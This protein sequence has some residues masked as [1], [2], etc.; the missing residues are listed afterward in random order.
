MKKLIIFFAPLTMVL[1]V[2][3]NSSNNKKADIPIP[4]AVSQQE[5]AQAQKPTYEPFP[6]DVYAKQPIN[7]FRDLS[8]GYPLT[9]KFVVKEDDKTYLTV[10]RPT[11]KKEF[12]TVQV[13]N[14]QYFFFEKR[15]ASVEITFHGWENYYNLENGMETKYGRPSA[16]A[17]LSKSWSDKDD[18][19]AFILFDRD[20]D[21]GSI[22]IW[23]GKYSDKCD[24]LTKNKISKDF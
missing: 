12:G 14:I 11:D 21:L 20:K 22:N 24:E 4:S 1:F 2:A 3:C 10:E 17:G 9:D 19:H 15:F 7:G 13:D 8:W 5:Q 16:N 6:A 18:N 23:N